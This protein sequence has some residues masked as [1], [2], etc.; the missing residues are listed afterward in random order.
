MS[1]IYYF[2]AGVMITLSLFGYQ[3]LTLRKYLNEY[4]QNSEKII[5]LLENI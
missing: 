5:D 1:L 4:V 3:Y 2:G